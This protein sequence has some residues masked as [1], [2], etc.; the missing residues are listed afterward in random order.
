MKEPKLLIYSPTE[1]HI[2]CLQVLV[3]TNKA[4]MNTQAHFIV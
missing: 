3:I 1:E 4:T 2:G